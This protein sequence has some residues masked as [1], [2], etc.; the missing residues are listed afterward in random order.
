[1]HTSGLSWCNNICH[2]Y[3]FSCKL[4]ETLRTLFDHYKSM[5]RSRVQIG[6][7]PSI[8]QKIPDKYFVVTNDELVRVKYV[9]VFSHRR[10][11][12]K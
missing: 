8:N 1:M 2:F 10:T 4:S 11:L 9:L 5:H 6:G 7:E 12:P 3:Y